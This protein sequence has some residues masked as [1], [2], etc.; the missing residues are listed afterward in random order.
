MASFDMPDMDQEVLA[1]LQD[2]MG[3]DFGKLVKSWQDDTRQRVS[4]ME[5]AIDVEDGVQLRQVAHSLKGS[6][7]NLGA[8]AVVDICIEM[9]KLANLKDMDAAK[10]A[11]PK[12]REAVLNAEQ[13]LLRLAS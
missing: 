1:E 13:E 6:S 9:E 8:R 7:S 11:L 5:A 3:S 10:M 4:A 2:I 12:L